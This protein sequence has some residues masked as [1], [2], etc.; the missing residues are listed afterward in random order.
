MAKVE[1]NGFTVNNVE[2]CPECKSEQYARID[3]VMGMVQVCCDKCDYV[4]D[5]AIMIR[6]TYDIH[7]NRKGF[8]EVTRKFFNLW[9]ESVANL[10]GYKSKRVRIIDQHK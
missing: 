8:I 7:T 6:G 10:K 4:A 9:N 2:P 3:G 5:G 1:M